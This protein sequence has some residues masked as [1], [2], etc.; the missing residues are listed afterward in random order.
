[1]WNLFTFPQ[2]ATPIG[3]PLQTR[4][5]MEKFPPTYNDAQAMIRIGGAAFRISLQ[6]V[7]FAFIEGTAQNRLDQFT[8]LLGVYR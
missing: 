3:V 8:K 7:M 5:P 2:S 1:M 6:N 4:A